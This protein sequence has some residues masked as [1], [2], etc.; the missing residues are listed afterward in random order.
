MSDLARVLK[1]HRSGQAF[2]R[3]LLARNPAHPTV[4]RVVDDRLFLL[5]LDELY[6]TGI[7]LHERTELLEGAR[8]LAQAL[9]ITPAGVPV[10]G[11]YSEDEQ[12][13]EYFRLMRALQQVD[14]S[15]RPRVA[16]MRDFQRLLQVTSS[17]LF[18]E[19]IFD[20]KLFPAG[21]DPLSRALLETTEWSI[22]TLTMLAHRFVNESDDYSLVGLACLTRDAVVL[23]ALRES[24]VLHAAA[25]TMGVGS[26]PL[27]VWRVSPEVAKRAERFVTTF[28][29]L[30]REE[31][32]APTAEHA[33]YY[34][35]AGLKANIS[36]RCVRIG[37]MPGAPAKF[38]HWAIYPDAEK[39]L[40]AQEFWHNEV[41]TTE[42]YRAALPNGGGPAP[43]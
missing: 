20:G 6:R 27:Y 36:G 14:A 35:A 31:L 12:L 3:D 40:N 19:A 15:A 18:G 9:E 26:L 17:P 42:R 1:D 33:D 4:E 38:Y 34:G 8:T 39:Q 37:Q 30:F 7:K 2:M 13:R 28:N 5:G 11:Y 25:V 41:W 23:T 29:A 43:V 21:R 32:P 24:V 10:E 16:S 22:G